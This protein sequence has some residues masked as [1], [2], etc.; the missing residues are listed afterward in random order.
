MSERHRSQGFKF[1][2]KS[3]LVVPGC[4][5]HQHNLMAWVCDV[6][7]TYI[8]YA[9]HPNYLHATPALPSSSHNTGGPRHFQWNCKISPKQMLLCGL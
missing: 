1:A 7:D 2:L 3:T 9:I 5:G 4:R 6:T 8:I